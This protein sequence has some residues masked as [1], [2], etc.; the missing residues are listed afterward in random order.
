MTEILQSND[1]KK[2]NFYF[3]HYFYPHDPYVLDENCKTVKEISDEL[4]GYQNAYNCVLHKLTQF[5]STIDK[6]DPNSTVLVL[7]DHG[8]NRF[9]NNDLNKL[10][11][12]IYIFNYSYS[13]NCSLKLDNMSSLNFFREHLACHYDI[14]FKYNH[15]NEYYDAESGKKILLNKVN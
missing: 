10:D 11:H 12:H 5:T 8:W 2:N 3:V 4:I 1:L 14:E 9:E 7:S 13:K 15:D 6:N